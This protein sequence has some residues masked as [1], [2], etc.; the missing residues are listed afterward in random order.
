MTP[1]ALSL[2]RDAPCALEAGRVPPRRTV[3]SVKQEDGTIPRN[4][5]YVG[6]GSTCTGFRRPSGRHS[7]VSRVCF[8]MTWVKELQA[9]CRGQGTW[10]AAC[11]NCS[12]KTASSWKPWMRHRP[13]RG[14]ERTERLH[15]LSNGGRGLVFHNSR[16][17]RCR[18]P[19]CGFSPS[20]TRRRI[21]CSTELCHPGAR[22]MPGRQ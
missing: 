20:S 12:R 16:C 6:Q 17:P 5:V 1:L 22:E 2:G 21:T 18:N 3:E 15:H 14:N 9:F 7:L 11:N 13:R 19:S 10:D 8:M 4:A